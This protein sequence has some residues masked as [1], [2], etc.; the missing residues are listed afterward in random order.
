MTARWG[1]ERTVTLEDGRLAAIRQVEPGDAQL[2][3]GLLDGLSAH[4]R[5]YRTAPTVADL[6]VLARRGVGFLAAEPGGRLVGAAWLTPLAHDEAEA[7]VALDGEYLACG[8]GAALL[9]QL[10]RIGRDEGIQFVTASVPLDN[11][12]MAA[13]FKAA[14]LRVLS[15]LPEGS[16]ASVVL[17]LEPLAVA[18]G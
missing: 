2:L 9:E 12:A 8:L 5:C 1:A 13:A 15:S 18:A 4:G 3:A 6:E 17:G 11:P 14:G 16:T 7:G 10:A